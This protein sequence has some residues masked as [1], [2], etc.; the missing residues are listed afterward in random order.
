MWHD[1]L[2]DRPARRRLLVTVLTFLTL[3]GALV[4]GVVTV[5]AQ[6]TPQFG[7]RPANPGPDSATSNY[8][9]LKAQPG[10][11]LT[12]SI[13]V[14]NPGTVPVKVLLYPVDA[15]TGQGGGAVYL[16]DGDPRT[17]VGA[18]V[19]LEATTIVVPPQ[20]QTTVNFTIAVPPTTKPGQHLGGIVAQLDRADTSP[21]AQPQ[22]TSFGVVT[23]TRA[24]TAVLIDVGMDT[25]APPAPAFTVTG[26]QVATVDGLPTLTV[27]IRNDGTAMGKPSGEV[28]LRDAAGRTVLQ[29]RFTLDTF[30]PQTSIQYPVQA[31][32]PATPGTY[33]VRVSLDFGGAAPAVYEGQVIITATA[34]ATAPPRSRL[35]QTPAPAAPSGKPVAA[36]PTGGGN[37]TMIAILGGV[38]GALAVGLIGLI[39]ALTRARKRQSR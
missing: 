16:S 31:E 30:L 4:Q 24:L 33:T 25:A 23:I 22:K 15:T 39:V 14:A 36:A 19:T 2:R 6:E 11:T 8:F 1:D 18:W 12:D 5:G 9:V 26:A 28:V 38:I 32:P 27:G 17:G 10:E 34:T 37:A 3:L 7:I 20:K 21:T 13:L 29:N 35:A